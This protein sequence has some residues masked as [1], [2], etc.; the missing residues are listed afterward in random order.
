MIDVVNRA[1]KRGLFES[2]DLIREIRDLRNKIAHEY[3]KEDQE[4]LFVDV[5]RLTPRLFGIADGIFAYCAR[6]GIK[7]PLHPA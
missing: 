3:S 2:V 7:R 5:M 4:K 6:F 1:D